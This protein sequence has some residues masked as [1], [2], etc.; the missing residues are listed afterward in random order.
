MLTKN[1]FQ[2]IAHQKSAPN[3]YRIVLQG[4]FDYAKVKPGCFVMLKLPDEA[5]QLRRPLAIAAC[6]AVRKTITLIYRIVGDGTR[7]LSELAVGTQ[8]NV[9]GPLGNGFPLEK[10]EPGAEVLLVGG[11]TGLPPL[12]LLAQALKEKGCKVST[13]IGFR[14]AAMIFGEEEF[15]C[16]GRLLLATDDGSKGFKGNVGELLTE[17]NST[18]QY[19]SVYACGPEGLLKMVQRHFSATEAAIYLSLESRMAC[20]MGACEACVVSTKDG[21]LN[22]RVCVEGPVFDGR[23]VTL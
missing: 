17:Q 14:T 8:L 3:I 15:E 16:T 12:M 19:T 10:V 4:E 7:L 9:L 5:Y 20:G 22:K 18:S 6:D 21:I 23:E 11:G 13:A 2:I 1:D